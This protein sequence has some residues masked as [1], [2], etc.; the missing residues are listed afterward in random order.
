M[1]N[2]VRSRDKEESA[3]TGP[4]LLEY[5]SEKEKTEF[6]SKRNDVGVITIRGDIPPAFSIPN[7][8]RLLVISDD[9]TYLTHGFHKYPAKF[10]PEYPRWAI[11]RFV[12]SPGHVVLDPFCGSGTTN[13]EARLHKQSS[14]GI[15]IDPLA[16]LIAKVKTTTLDVPC[17]KNS[18]RRIL[19]RLG[20]QAHDSTLIP[21]FPNRDYWF[22]P[23]V[24]Q[25][26]TY[27]KKTIQ[28]EVDDED[29][30]DFFFV[31]LSSIIR[32]VSNADSDL[33]LPKIS[34]FMR[35]K[36]KKGRKIDVF[37]AF[38]KVLA[39]QVPKMIL[40]STKCPK[41]EPYFSKII[42]G[43]AR[44]IDIPDECIDLAITSPPYLNAHDYVRA[45][46]LEMYWL[47]L[48]R[49]PNQKLQ[50][51]AKYVGSER[52]HV[53]QYEILHKT[54]KP[55]LDEALSKVYSKDRRRSYI[56][57]R[58]FSDMMKTFEEVYRLLRPGSHYVMFTGDN[59]IRKIPVPTHLYLKESAEEAGFETVSTFSSELI[60]RFE[61]SRAHVRDVHGGFI[62][63]DWV[64]ILKKH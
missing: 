61:I 34:R 53:H 9:Q 14:Y 33:V 58:Y 56:V 54:G 50:L 10:I 17:L 42:E 40:F 41:D 7:E 5:C 23:A 30:R 24:S 1:E 37:E 20:A 25:N 52:A 11:E 21:D 15:D 2:K 28:E 62:A 16:R 47:G 57:F 31:C 60:K 63:E 3:Q 12:A 27:L 35:E 6:L 55:E 26:L 8:A 13:V 36:E 43:D 59:V 51:A 29:V 4:D 64:L 38:R 18:Q 32:S 22:R 19:A 39:K 49:N 44:N 48:L 45:H 46:H